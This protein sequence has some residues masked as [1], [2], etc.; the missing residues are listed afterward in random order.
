[1]SAGA[2]RPPITVIAAVSDDGFIGKDGDLPWRLPADLQRFKALTLGHALIMGR[3][4]FDSIGRA[5]PG[6]TTVVL[7]RGQPALPDGVLIASSLDEAIARCGEVERIFI[8]GGEA[9]YALG[10]PVADA[11][12]L[13]RVHHEVVDGNARFPPWDRSGWSKVASDEHP[14]D[15]KNAHAYAF[16]RWER[17][18]SV[19][20]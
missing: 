11:V 2:A 12:E 8:A 3:K 15:E 1:M 17:T 13:T 19:T 20:G 6:R 10:L 5:L 7:S 18:V 9:I 16:E 14:A 4:T